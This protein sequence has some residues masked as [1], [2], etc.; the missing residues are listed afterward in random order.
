M[1]VR[2]ENEDGV[3]KTWP[4]ERQS[5]STEEMFIAVR[6]HAAARGVAVVL[7]DDVRCVVFDR[8]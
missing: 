5:G 7:E 3:H 1:R 2:W 8:T 6:D 4:G